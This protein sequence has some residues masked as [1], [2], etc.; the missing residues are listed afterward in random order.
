MDDLTQQLRE[1][2]TAKALRTGLFHD[3]VDAIMQDVQVWHEVQ[4][5]VRERSAYEQGWYDRH[6]TTID[7]AVMAGSR[8]HARFPLPTRT[9]EV[10]R[11]E[12][13]PG[14]DYP[15]LCVTGGV[16]CSVNPN[17]TRTPRQ[18]AP[19]DFTTMRHALDLYNCPTRTETVPVDESNPWGDG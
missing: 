16:L 1:R 7:H 4:A 17:G 11:E 9:R 19:S 13:V 6:D 10:L 3:M 2:I 14:T 12:P 15:A 18:I 5:R 8:V